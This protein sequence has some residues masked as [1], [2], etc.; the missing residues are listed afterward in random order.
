MS[1]PPF[2]PLHHSQKLSALDGVLVMEVGIGRVGAL[3]QEGAVSSVV[4]R[5]LQ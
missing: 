2:S 3:V 4:L 1:F 5:E